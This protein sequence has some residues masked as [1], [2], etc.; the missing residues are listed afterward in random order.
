MGR[1]TVSLEKSLYKK[2]MT[3]AAN[4]EIYTFTEL[5]RQLLTHYT[6]DEASLRTEKK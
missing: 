6:R 3:K 2:A 4:Q 1:H 5:I